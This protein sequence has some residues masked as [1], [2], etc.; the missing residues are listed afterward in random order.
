MP[1]MKIISQILLSLKNPEVWLLESHSWTPPSPSTLYFYLLK[2]TKFLVKISQFEFLVMTQQRILVYKLFLSLNIPNFSLF[3]VIKLQ[4]TPEK[5]HHLL[6]QQPPLKTEVLSSHPP[7]WKCDRRFI[8][9]SRKGGGGAHYGGCFKKGSALS[10][11]FILTVPFQHYLS[12]KRW[13][14]VFCL[15]TPYISV[16]CGRTQYS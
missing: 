4:P 7:F 15:F 10:L 3:F 8:P 1:K 6:S 11:I 5:S 9:P 12:L 2:V 13:W 14:C 16:F